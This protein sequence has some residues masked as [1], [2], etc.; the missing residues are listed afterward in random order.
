MNHTA[1]R[2]ISRMAEIEVTQAD[3]K[4]ATG[5]GKATISSWIKGD[6]KPSGMY[7]TQLASFLRCSTDWLLYDGLETNNLYHTHN[8]LSKEQIKE[9]M[10]PI[11]NWET[12]N[13][14]NENISKKDIISWIPKHQ[15]LSQKAFGLVVQGRSMWPEFKPNDII[16][17]EP[18]IILKDLKDGDFIVVQTEAD[19]PPILTQLIIGN[20]QEDRYLKMINPDWSTKAM[21]PMDTY[22]LVGVVDSKLVRYRK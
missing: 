3:I 9:T 13:V 21:I 2:I 5:A 19:K 18:K 22:L 6:T 7:A 4:R 10:I 12:A 16:Y 17:V 11:I 15:H 1:D 14:Y 8:V 20:C